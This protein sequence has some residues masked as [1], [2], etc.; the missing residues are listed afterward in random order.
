MPIITLTT[1]IAAPIETVFDLSRSIDLH[2]ASTAQTN[3]R[4]VAG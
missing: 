2:I 3:E 1:A 4:A